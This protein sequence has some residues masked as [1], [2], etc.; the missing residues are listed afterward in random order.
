MV[1]SAIASWR[2][3]ASAPDEPVWHRRCAVALRVMTIATCTL[4][5]LLALAIIGSLRSSRFDEKSLTMLL[6]MLCV[7][8][9]AAGSLTFV[10]AIPIA[11]QVRDRPGAIQAFALA[12]LIPTLFALAGIVMMQHEQRESPA[13]AITLLVLSV[14]IAVWASIFLVGF[15]VVLKRAA[16][17]QML[18]GLVR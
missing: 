1:V 14:G 17:R 11:R 12:I 9:A 3:A 7:S 13:L 10:R 15:S 8:W 6:G 18:D 2:Y 16:M 5:I 4:Q